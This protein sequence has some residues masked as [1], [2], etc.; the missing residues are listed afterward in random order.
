MIGPGAEHGRQV[1]DEV[2]V[3]AD[4]RQPAGAVAPHRHEDVEPEIGLGAAPGPS[5]RLGG[6]EL[7]PHEDLLRR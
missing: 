3:L 7:N 6:T 5:S 2:V 1:T 4:H